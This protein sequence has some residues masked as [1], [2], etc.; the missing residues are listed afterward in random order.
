MA[1]TPWILRAFA[2]LLAVV[3]GTAMAQEK[4]LRIATQNP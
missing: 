4:T 2:V 3:A 1:R